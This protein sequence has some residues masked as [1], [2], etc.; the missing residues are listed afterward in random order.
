MRRT[1]DPMIDLFVGLMEM[2]TSLVKPAG[3]IKSGVKE[4]DAMMRNSFEELSKS[5]KEMWEEFDFEY[6]K[7]DII[8]RENG[9]TIKAVMPGFRKED[10]KVDVNDNVLIITGENIIK[11]EDENIYIIKEIRTGKYK[12]I[13]SLEGYNKESIKAKYENGILY[14]D[15]DKIEKEPAYQKNINI[16]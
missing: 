7:S 2:P 9:I 5:S 15:V 14:V 1:N 4:M 10:I 13:F 16:D 11:E 6:I 12:R 8:K 3:Y